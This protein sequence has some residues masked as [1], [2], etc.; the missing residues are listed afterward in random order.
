MMTYVLIIGSCLSPT[1]KV[2]RRDAEILSEA[3]EGEGET[4]FLDWLCH[5]G[6]EKRLTLPSMLLQ[7]QSPLG[8]NGDLAAALYL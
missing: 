2:P 5:G 4:N 6:E 8:N 7:F 1:S 3:E